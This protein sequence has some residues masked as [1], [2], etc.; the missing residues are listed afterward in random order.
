MLVTNS[1]ARGC[2]ALAQA[3]Q[4]SCGCSIPGGIQSQVGWDPG[5]PNLVGSKGGNPARGRGLEL[6]EL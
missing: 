1:S 3:A 2:E 6:D 4:R 5:Q